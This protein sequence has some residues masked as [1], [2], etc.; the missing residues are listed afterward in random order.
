MKARLLLLSFMLP[1]LFT[2]PA[3]ALGVDT[4]DS[5]P[6]KA[7]ICYFNVSDGDL[8]ILDN[9]SQ[10]EVIAYYT[11]RGFM[12]SADFEVLKEERKRKWHE[13]S[14]RRAK[15]ERNGLPF[16]EVMPEI[17]ADPQF[18]AARSRLVVSSGEA[19][20]ES[21]VAPTDD[22][23]KPVR[24][25]Y[26]PHKLAQ[27]L[28]SPPSWLRKVDPSPEFLR[29]NFG[30][31]W[32]TEYAPPLGFGF[33]IEGNPNLTPRGSCPVVLDAGGLTIQ[34]FGTCAWGALDTAAADAVLRAE[35][36]YFAR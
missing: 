14:L 24:V 7:A 26:D 10:R 8:L 36:R 29:A 20:C 2:Q 32:V 18:L 12:T 16:N 33:R 34:S 15:A 23:Y 27:L 17:A 13:Q 9:L 5:E 11:E 30:N 25:A 6:S 28:F 21:A 22:Y 35:D 3:D 31:D 1:G 19:E 4:T